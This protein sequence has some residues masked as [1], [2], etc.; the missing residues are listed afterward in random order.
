MARVTRRVRG[1][2]L[3]D[4][5]EGEWFEVGSNTA[6]ALLRQGEQMRK[7][8]GTNPITIRTD[9]VRVDGIAG[10]MLARGT[11][12]QIVPKFL[13]GDSGPWV[14]GLN[15]YL[16]YA[17]RNHTHLGTA[18]IQTESLSSFVDNTAYQFCEM[19]EIAARAGLPRTYSNRRVTGQSPRG[20]LDVTASIRNL[21]SLRP[22]LEWD[23]V[24]LN[25]DTPAVR[26][27][28]LALQLLARQ[29][30]DAQVQRRVE[31]NLSMWPVVP[32]T[33]PSR[34]PILP[35]SFA[36]FGPVVALAY[37]I[38][39]GLGRAPGA[40]DA[41]Y[42]YVVNMVKTF[43][44]TVERALA[45]STQLFDDRDLSVVRQDSVKF[46][47]AL[48][49]G[50]DDYK[51]VPDAVVYESGLPLVVVDAK[52]KSFEDRKDGNTAIRPANDDFY[53]VLTAAIAHEARLA[54]LL[55]PAR[56]GLLGGTAGMN[57]WR[58]SVGST[59]AV[60]LAA[61]AM[62]VV[63]LSSGTTASQ[64]H[65]QVKSLLEELMAIS[66]TQP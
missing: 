42:A 3:V 58:I 30:R 24:A 64:M 9:S 7:S 45:A 62:N 16:N 66:G 5:R 6:A 28:R 49:A 11:P 29:C 1:K 18:R 21:A 43:E 46:G 17:G 59:R 60:T 65:N 19:L 41:G 10:A 54:L 56:P 55:Y 48:I 36:H 23:E 40:E 22:I 63:G 53:Q 12:I 37:E 51:S 39:L 38:C 26:V 52:Y 2:P 31:L 32:P 34:I 13:Q 20:R 61:G 57:A 50:S 27:V 15:T 4:V 35:R 44:R 47:H 14:K 8:L 25:E 33:M